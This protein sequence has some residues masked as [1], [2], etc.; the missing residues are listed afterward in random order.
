MIKEQ[1]HIQFEVEHN[2]YWV[3]DSSTTITVHPAKD[4]LILHISFFELTEYI[5]RRSR[6]EGES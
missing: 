5:N 1:F 4:W 6:L 3:T 2:S